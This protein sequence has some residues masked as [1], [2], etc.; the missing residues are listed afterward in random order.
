MSEL[1]KQELHNLGMNV[2]GKKLE[3]LKYEFL[4]IN[5]DLKKNPQFIVKNIKGELGFVVVRTVVFP[6]EPDKYDRIWMETFKVHAVSKNAKLLYAGIGLANDD[7]MTKPLTKDSSYL[8]K[9]NGLQ[10]TVK[11]TGCY[12]SLFFKFDGGKKVYEH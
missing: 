3:K 5:S 6:D 8:V 9:F 7:D 10:E 2:I 1:T 12:R 4:A 11:N